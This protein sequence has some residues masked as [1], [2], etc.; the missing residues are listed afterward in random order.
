VSAR[1]ARWATALAVLA[2]AVIGG[3]VSFDH[4][5]TLALANGYSPATARLLPFTVDGL[6]VAASMS[7]MTGTRPGLAR[8][9]LVLGIAATVAANAV[10]GA[11]HGP[12]G[13]VVNMWPAVAFLVSSELLIGMLRARPATAPET[14]TSTPLAGDAAGT[15]SVTQAVT[16]DVTQAV[17]TVEA[18]PASTVPPKRERRARTVSVPGG[19]TRID[20]KRRPAPERVF[21]AE[22]AAGQ[23]PSLR[24]V[25]ERA[26]VG[27]PR[28][29]EILAELAELID[30]SQA[31]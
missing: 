13:V 8:V 17:S 5:Q 12:V 6:I 14:V 4:V 15:G 27:T 23:L 20:A 18:V 2:V 3:V 26:H 19:P 30:T 28:A 21:A 22:L 11:G 31:A 7:L 29:R 16:V 10:Y 9:A 25:K 24:A 1:L